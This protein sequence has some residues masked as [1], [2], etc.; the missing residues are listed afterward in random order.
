MKQFVD[1]EGLKLFLELFKDALANNGPKEEEV[2]DETEESTIIMAL[3]KKKIQVKK[4]RNL[5]Q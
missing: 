4:L 2:I 1:L 3:L 5:L